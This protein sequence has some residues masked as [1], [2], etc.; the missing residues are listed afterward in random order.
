MFARSAKRP[1]RPPYGWSAFGVV[2]GLI[3]ALVFF[4]PA[5][6]LAQG[7][8]KLSAG[9]VQLLATRGTVWNGSGQLVLTG[10]AQSH[11][12]LALPTR[13]NWQIRLGWK[14]LRVQLETPCCTAQPLEF[15]LEPGW[16]SA[17][18]RLHDQQSE[19][20]AALLSGLGTPWNTLL[21]QGKLQLNTQN[22]VFSLTKGRFQI[23]GQ[24]RL[25]MLDMSSTLAQIKPVGSY[26][27]TLRGGPSPSV[28]LETLPASKLLLSG[29]GNWVGSRLHFQGE[30]STDPQ[31][32]DA[33]SNLLNV[34]GRREGARSIIQLG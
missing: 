11:D 22:L 7:L 14:K 16:G 1:S 10:G 27:L 18:L 26:R 17:T 15:E 21:P 20:P 28:Q 3:L 29:T 19:W 25:D 9:Q 33:L 34:V 31:Y 30:A 8:D 12:A 6:W 24:A 4:A 13:I 2:V 23:E 5:Q 32:A